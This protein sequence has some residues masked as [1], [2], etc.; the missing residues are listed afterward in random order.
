MFYVK[1]PVLANRVVYPQIF[2]DRFIHDI[3]MIND[4]SMSVE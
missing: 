3:I 2:E 4:K 1:L